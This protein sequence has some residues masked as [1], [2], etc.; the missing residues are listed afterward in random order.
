MFDDNNDNDDFAF[1]FILIKIILNAL[2]Q[3]NG[4]SVDFT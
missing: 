2:R 4:V 3:L 1:R